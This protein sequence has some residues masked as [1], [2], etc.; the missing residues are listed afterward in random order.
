MIPRIFQKNIKTA[1]NVANLLYFKNS[2]KFF[3]C[4]LR[5]IGEDRL[6]LFATYLIHLKSLLLVCL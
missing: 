2:F 1:V 5:D 3:A 6:C 4:L